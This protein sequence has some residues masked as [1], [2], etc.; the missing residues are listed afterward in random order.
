MAQ[1]D[2]YHLYV[3]THRC[4]SSISLIT[5]SFCLR[6]LLSPTQH[7]PRSLS[8]LQPSTTFFLPPLPYIPQ[9]GSTPSLRFTQASSS[10]PLHP[11]L[12][13]LQHASSPSPAATRS[14]PCRS[15]RLSSGG[16]VRWSMRERMRMEGRCITWSW[17]SREGR[18]KGSLLGC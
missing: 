10:S 16:V 3:P 17:G 11:T 13:P 6:P 8:G 7:T 2:L 15:E 18:R 12:P 5:L 14:G 9:H 1:R 4:N